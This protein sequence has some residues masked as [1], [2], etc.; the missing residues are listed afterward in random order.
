[1]LG[2]QSQLHGVRMTIPATRTLTANP[3]DRHEPPGGT[4]RSAD[5]TQANSH[6]EVTSS[7]RFAGINLVADKLDELRNS[8]KADPEIPAIDI[9]S[10]KT[11]AEFMLAQPR[12]ATRSIGV[13]EEGFVDA[14]WFLSPTIE[15]S[16]AEI[17]TKE[18]RFW[19]DGRGMLVMIFLPDGMAHFAA[20]SGPT[21]GGRIRLRKSATCSLEMIPDEL[22]GFWP[23]VSTS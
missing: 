22:V 2:L 3:S 8:S 1:M 5:L 7:L 10:L 9:R 15:S 17:E 14:Q 12:L 16:A 13:N 23:R 19:G 6:D 11:F 18:S 21:I 4:N 20:N